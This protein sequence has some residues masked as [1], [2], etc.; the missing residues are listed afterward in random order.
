MNVPVLR[1]LAAWGAITAVGLL[2]R[3]GWALWSAVL[4]CASFVG[5]TGLLVAAALAFPVRT[6]STQEGKVVLASF[7]LILAVAGVSWFC[8]LQG[9]SVRAQFGAPRVAPGGLPVSAWLIAWFIIIDGVMR[10]A[11]AVDVPFVAIFAIPFGGWAARGLAI[12]F[13]AFDASVGILMLRRQPAGWAWGIARC[14]LGTANSALFVLLP[15]FAD[16]LQ[17]IRT[18]MKTPS[19]HPEAVRM[20]D[21]LEA[22]AWLVAMC[23]LLAR[24]SG[25]ART[26]RLEQIASEQEL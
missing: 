25:F 12:G 7:L 17:T 23:F 18:I 15:G 8:Y 13:V 26:E 2:R 20:I 24:R 19:T 5:G 6:S 16:R 11:E 1:A 14:A 21:L 9:D 3:R 22:A 10:L 4:F